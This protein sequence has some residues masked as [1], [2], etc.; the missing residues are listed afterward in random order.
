MG[1]LPLVSIATSA[2]I[3]RPRIPSVASAQRGPGIA[4]ARAVPDRFPVVSNQR[5]RCTF[6]QTTYTRSRTHVCTAASH[7]GASANAASVH[8]VNDETVLD[9]EVVEE[10]PC[11]RRE[12]ERMYQL[13]YADVPDSLGRERSDSLIDEVERMARE[14]NAA[15]A[16]ISDLPGLLDEVQALTSALQASGM[17]QDSKSERSKAR[18]ASR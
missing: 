3:A 8:I 16:E 7:N 1:R 13:S 4:S 5:P 11:S 14:A 15:L 9:G 2:S 10:S 6:C 18:A 17:K 12:L